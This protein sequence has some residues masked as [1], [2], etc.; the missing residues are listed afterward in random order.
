MRIGVFSNSNVNIL[1]GLNYNR[2]VAST[3][4]HLNIYKKNMTFVFLLKWN[5]II[6]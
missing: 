4:K 1:Q 3:Y 5:Q 6:P 2:R